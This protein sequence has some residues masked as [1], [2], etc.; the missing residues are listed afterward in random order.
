M[1]VK[2][3]RSSVMTTKQKLK[4]YDNRSK[5]KLKEEVNNLVPGVYASLAIALHRNWGWG[6]KRIN[7]L[8]SQSQRIWEDLGTDNMIELCEKE[9]NILLKGE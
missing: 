6:F 4:E 5:Q 9:T 7:R 2:F 8:F 3:R 1:N